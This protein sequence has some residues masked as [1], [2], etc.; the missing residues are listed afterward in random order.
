MIMVNNP[1]EEKVMAQINSGRVKLRSRYIFL[2]EK[3]GLGS[4]LALSVLLAVLFFDLV[5]FYL[6]SSDNLGYLSFGSYGWL[7]FLESFPYGLVA[8]LLILMFA[9]GFIIKTSDWAYKQSFGHLA[10]ALVGSVVLAGTVLAFTN[11]AEQ[12]ERAAYGPMGPGRMFRPLLERGINNRQRG[13]A[14]KVVVIGRDFVVVQTPQALITIDTSDLTRVPDGLAT[15][16]FV[17]SVGDRFENT[18]KAK[19]IRIMPDEEAPMIRR[20]VGRR[21]D[22]FPLPPPLMTK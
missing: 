2:A 21:F 9:A 13:L 1:I 4:A 8:L 20:G 19:G 15:G 6:K 22:F 3:F 17:M 11:V 10:M 7:A 14:G 16:T 5:F 12:I 18:F